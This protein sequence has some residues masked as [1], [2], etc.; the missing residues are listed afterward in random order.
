MKIFKCDKCPKSFSR[1]MHLTR[2]A[3]IHEKK[4]GHFCDYCEKWFPSR[5]SLNRHTRIHTGNKIEIINACQYFDL[6]F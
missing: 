6:L 2:H 1:R 5:S 4:Q 3:S